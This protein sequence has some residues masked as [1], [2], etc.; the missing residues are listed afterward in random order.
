M[1]SYVTAWSPIQMWTSIL[2]FGMC[3]KE[4]QLKSHPTKWV[5]LIRH[6][7]ASTYVAAAARSISKSTMDIKNLF[8]FRFYWNL[9]FG[10]IF[11][12]FWGRSINFQHI[13]IA[14]NSVEQQWTS[15][16]HFFNTN[17]LSTL[18]ILLKHIKVDRHEFFIDSS[19]SLS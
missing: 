2:C 12:T 11:F 10:S 16:Q 13:Y 3:K 1:K 6:I 18:P 8:F 14:K 17:I 19:G 7:Y 15:R 9:H 5:F 4:T